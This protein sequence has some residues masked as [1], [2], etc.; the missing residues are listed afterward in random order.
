MFKN[1][2]FKDLL[3]NGIKILGVPVHILN[4][5]GAYEVSPKSFKRLNKIIA[6]GK[7]ENKDELEFSVDVSSVDLKK[8]GFNDIINI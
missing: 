7:R 3:L 2:V 1:L 4:E 6:L 8:Q 5:R